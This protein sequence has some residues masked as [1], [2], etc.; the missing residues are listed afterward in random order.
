MHDVDRKQMEY[1]SEL[2]EYG[3]I[4][5]LASEQYEYSGE[6]GSLLESIFGE[7]QAEAA[8][9]GGGYQ[10]VP[11]PEIM[12]VQLASELLEVGN[13]HE[14]DHFLGSLISRAVSAA[15]IP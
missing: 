10:E 8:L 9:E 1:G 13:E 4:P 3:E 14:L 15:G 7:A 11:L 12:E 2:S 5:E 6:Q